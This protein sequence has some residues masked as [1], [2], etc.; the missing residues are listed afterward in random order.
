MSVLIDPAGAL[1][2]ALD[3]AAPSERIVAAVRELQ[4]L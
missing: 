2:R 1:R 4:L 3:Y